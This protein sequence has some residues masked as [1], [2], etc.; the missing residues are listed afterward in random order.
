MIL[1]K[2]KTVESKEMKYGRDEVDAVQ[3]FSYEAWLLLAKPLYI[4]HN[5]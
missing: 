5:L 4:L 1:K 3:K 2:K